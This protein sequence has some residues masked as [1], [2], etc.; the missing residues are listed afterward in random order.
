MTDED[1]CPH[2][3]LIC[4]ECLRLA[5][6]APSNP[7]LQ[8]LVALIRKQLGASDHLTATAEEL[9]QFVLEIVDLTLAEVDR[10]GTHAQKSPG[11]S[12]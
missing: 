6:E 10:Q 2:G 8:P 3:N 7:H 11:V 4:V 1:I 5:K 9:A 12:G